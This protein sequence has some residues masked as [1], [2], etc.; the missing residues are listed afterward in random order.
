MPSDVNYYLAKIPPLHAGKPNFMAEVQGILQPF[1]DAQALINALPAYF[2]L[3][4]AIGVQLDV[5]GQWIGR[6]RNVPIPLQTCFFSLGDPLR[7]L[8]KGVWKDNFNPGAALSVLDDNVYRRLLQ[9]VAIANEW[10][11]SVTAAQQVMDAYFPPGQGTSTFVQDQGWGVAAGQQIQM[12]MT[13]GISGKIP[14]IVDLEVLSQDLLGI[15]PGGV[16]A[17]YAV[18]SID[19]APIFGLGVNNN[20]IGGLGV[21]ALA[22]SSDFILS[23]D[24]ALLIPG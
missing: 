24:A 6:T 13:I 9:A 20:Y 2:D 1:C 5:C 21:G 14:S 7:G 8:G 11:G 22:V 17:T 19:G 15:K 10:D 12:T 4:Q 16:A 18:T 3:D 23:A